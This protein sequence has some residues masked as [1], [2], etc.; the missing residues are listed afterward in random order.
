MLDMLTCHICSHT[1]YSMKYA[2]YY[3]RALCPHRLPCVRAPAF[4]LQLFIHLSVFF[5][6]LFTA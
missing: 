6:L 4:L 2:R 1:I 3:V 5:S